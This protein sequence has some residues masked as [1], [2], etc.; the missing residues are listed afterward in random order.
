M[1]KLWCYL[2]GDN[3]IFRISISPTQ[4]I[5]DLKEQICHECSN[6]IKCDAAQLAL[7]KVRYIMI[8]VN[9]DVTTPVGR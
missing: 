2:E 1:I 9:I 3:E 6:S 4:T 7:T 5:Y 8:S